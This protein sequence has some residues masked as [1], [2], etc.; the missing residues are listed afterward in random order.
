MALARSLVETDPENA[1]AGLG[2]SRAGWE[3]PSGVIPPAGPKQAAPPW[4]SGLE[5]PD[6]AGRQAV[7]LE[8]ITG[9]PDGHMNQN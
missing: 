8:G 6:N 9:S 1:N 3:A 2:G 5:P 4:K 7:W